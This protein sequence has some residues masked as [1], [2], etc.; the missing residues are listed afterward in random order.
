MGVQSFFLDDTSLEKKRSLFEFIK[1]IKSWRF[2][3]DTPLSSIYNDSRKAVS[4]G[5]KSWTH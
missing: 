1:D 4:K 5:E 3:F 2:L